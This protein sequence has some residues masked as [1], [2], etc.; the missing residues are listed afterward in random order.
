MNSH[1]LCN[2]YTKRLWKEVYLN[3]NLDAYMYTKRVYGVCNCP[4][5]EIVLS[6]CFMFQ[7]RQLTILSIP[8]KDQG[9]Y[10]QNNQR[11]KVA[12]KWPSLEKL[13]KIRDVSVLNVGLYV[14]GI[15]VIHK[16]ST[17]LHL[18]ELLI[19][20]RMIFRTQFVCSFFKCTYIK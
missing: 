15:G 14:F 8:S 16:T 10:S 1:V 20:P 7:Q 18:S 13:L 2:I 19:K 5:D 9:L 6:T 17:K 3:I 11:L 12:S 4:W